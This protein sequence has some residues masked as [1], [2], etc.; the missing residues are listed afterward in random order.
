[1][2]VPNTNRAAFD[3]LV[4]KLQQT[5]SAA[6]LPPPAPSS[7]VAT[8]PRTATP[9]LRNAMTKIGSA[10]MRALV[11]IRLVNGDNNVSISN[12]AVICMLV[13]MMLQPAFD[14]ASAAAL[15]TVMGNYSYK[16][17]IKEG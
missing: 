1:M 6:S 5:N 14:L 15:L 17:Y 2:S 3:A 9:F 4:A 13:K 16:R 7:S 10:I 11:F 12:I 8:A